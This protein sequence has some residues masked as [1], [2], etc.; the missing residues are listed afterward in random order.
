MHI[1]KRARFFLLAAYLA[2]TAVVFLYFNIPLLVEWVALILFVGAVIAGRAK[3][4]FRDWG[5][6]VIALLA[7]QLTSP[8]AT[9]LATPWH[10][11]ELI[12]ADRFLFRGTVPTQWLQV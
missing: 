2:I 6:F 8:I 1:P 7:W 3:L 4:F 12:S 10:L 9:E 5:V 11:S